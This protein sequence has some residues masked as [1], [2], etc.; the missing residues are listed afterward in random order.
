M[1]STNENLIDPLDQSQTDKSLW[2]YVSKLDSVEGGRILFKC[3]FRNMTFTGS[4]S[5]V[6]THLLKISDQGVRGCAKTTPQ[7]LNELKKENKETEFRAKN[8]K[9]KSVLLSPVSNQKESS[10]GSNIISLLFHWIT[11][12]EEK[13]Q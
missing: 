2:G 11:F 5:R 6:K 7:H 12:K 3:N 9:S 10:S 8:A 1:S 4:Y 13:R